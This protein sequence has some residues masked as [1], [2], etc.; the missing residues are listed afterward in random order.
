MV[1]MNGTAGH[2]ARRIQGFDYPL[3]DGPVILFSDG[4]S[5]NWSWQTYA[6]HAGRHPT[7]LAA[8]LYRDNVRGRDDATVL[9]ARLARTT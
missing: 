5:A 3:G 6:E 7:L 9:V 2:N 4:I 8:L 1:S